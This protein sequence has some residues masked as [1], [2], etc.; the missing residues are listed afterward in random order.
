[1]GSM[2]E[3][4]KQI[5]MLREG[6]NVKRCHAL[7]HNDPGYTDGKHSFDAVS[8][9]LVLHPDPHMDLVKYMLWH[10]MGERYVGDLPASAKW[11]SPE[12]RACYEILE[13][14]VLKSKLPA[15]IAAWDRLSADDRT[16]VAA[17]DML[18][19]RMW[20]EDQ[21][22]AGNNHVHQ[23]HRSIRR[24][25]NEFSDAGHMPKEVQQF[26]Q[27]GGAKWERLPERFDDNG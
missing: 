2:E 24:A 25:L 18:E 21:I 4:I 5:R 7:Y 17:L 13:K 12:L 20:C 16:W 27:E 3:K 22:A 9:L 6:G 19:F 1:M 23:A 10:D 11:A 8:M 14:T 15:I 26:I